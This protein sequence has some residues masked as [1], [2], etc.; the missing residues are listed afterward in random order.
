ML[1]YTYKSV[2]MTYTYLEPII[3]YLGIDMPHPPFGDGGIGGLPMKTI[4]RNVKARNR[5]AF[6][7]GFVSGLSPSLPVWEDWCDHPPIHK[8]SSLSKIWSDV[9]AHIDDAANVVIPSAHGRR[10][11]RI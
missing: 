7:D 1:D 10:T 9:G 6:I 11:G 3:Q 8:P 2:Y 4:A 5:R